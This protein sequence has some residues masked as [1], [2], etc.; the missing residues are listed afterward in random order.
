MRSNFL[1]RSRI[2][3]GKSELETELRVEKV[4]VIVDARR[5]NEVAGEEV[6]IAE[7]DVGV[8]IELDLDSKVQFLAD[9]SAEVAAGGVA[10]LGSGRVVQGVTGLIEVEDVPP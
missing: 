2:P 5:G 8:L 1:I 10:D 6:R 9:V 4:G 3:R 7:E